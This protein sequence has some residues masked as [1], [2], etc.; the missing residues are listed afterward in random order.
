[1]KLAN[2]FGEA[3]LLKD[4]EDWDVMDDDVNNDSQ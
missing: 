3:H 1:M 2:V 4:W